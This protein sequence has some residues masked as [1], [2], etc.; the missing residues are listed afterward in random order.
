MNGMTEAQKQSLKQMQGHRL[1]AR[2]HTGGL[3]VVF[4]QK[5]HDAK[6]IDLD[7]RVWS[8]SH[9]LAVV[10]HGTAPQGDRQ[11]RAS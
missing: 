10:D 4:A 2:F 8:P 5:Y 7:G 9:Y 1:I 3:V 11:R 6:V